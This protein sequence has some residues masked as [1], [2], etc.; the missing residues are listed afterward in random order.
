MKTIINYLRRSILLC[1]CMCVYILQ[2]QQSKIDSLQGL[3]RTTNLD[4]AKANILNALAMEFRGNN[5]DTAVYYAKQAISLSEKTNFKMGMGEAY[6]WYGIGLSNLGK[7]DEALKQFAKAK[8]LFEQLLS[9]QTADAGKI[10]QLLGRIINSTGVVFY[11]QG[12]FS[13]ALKN[14][15]AALKIRREIGNKKEEADCYNNMGVVY[16][17]QGN[18]GEALKNNFASLKIMGERGDKKSRL[19]ERTIILALFIL[20]R[21]IIQKH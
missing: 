6:L 7:F 10:K 18:Y 17:E 13:E 4:T 19:L 2:A 21:V 3:L 14:Y 15:S 16:I 8:T 5:P 1:F 11:R 9:V 20:I 12:N